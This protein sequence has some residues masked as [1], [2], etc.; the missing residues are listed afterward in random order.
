MTLCFHV[1]YSN[2]NLSV[3]KMPSVIFVFFMLISSFLPLPPP[4]MNF[5][6]SKVCVGVCSWTLSTWFFF[7][8]YAPAVGSSGCFLKFMGDDESPMLV[9]QF[10][11]P[12]EI[13]IEAQLVLYIS[14]KGGD[15]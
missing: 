4:P 6:P 12:H 11:Y 3:I 8:Q 7:C 9:P 10:C 14:Q 1:A 15:A 5:P 2:S 13:I